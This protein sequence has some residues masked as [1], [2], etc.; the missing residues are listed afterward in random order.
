MP[1]APGGFTVM[2]DTF[3]TLNATSLASSLTT[4]ASPSDMLD[5]QLDY[6]QLKNDGAIFR[7][8]KCVFLKCT[9]DMLFCKNTP[10]CMIHSLHRS[11]RLLSSVSKSVEV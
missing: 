6:L 2:A 1:G 8:L 11:P 5:A 4:E 9:A 10:L 3:A 7:F